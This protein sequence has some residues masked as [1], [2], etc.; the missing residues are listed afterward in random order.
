LLDKI[1]KLQITYWNY[2]GEDVSIT[3]IGPTAQDFYNV[4]GIGADSISISTIDPSGIALAAI[5]ELN[6]K[7]NSIDELEQKV[8]QLKV[9]VET[10]LTQLSN[11]DIPKKS[12]SMK[13]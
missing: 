3:H 2:K 11:S 13:K 4:F 1:S 5:K 10:L 7:I 12:L 8:A 9:I 6:E